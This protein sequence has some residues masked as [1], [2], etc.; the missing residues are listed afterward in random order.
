[1][2]KNYYAVIPSDVL[3]DTRLTDFEKL[4]FASIASLTNSEG[5]CF[6]SNAYF[7]SV[8]SKSERTIQYAIKHLQ[9]LDYIYIYF[10]PLKNK[11]FIYL[12]E[13]LARKS[14]SIGGVQSVSPPPRNQLHPLSLIIKSL[15]LRL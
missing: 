9:E 11:R 2:K 3:T 4:L 1:M 10:N 13:A 8:F 12:F 14:F 15:V 6:A 7:V 5:F